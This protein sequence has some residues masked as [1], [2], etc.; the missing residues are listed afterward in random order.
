MRARRLTKQFGQFSRKLFLYP[1]QR[2]RRSSLVRRARLPRDSSGAMSDGEADNGEPADARDL[3]TWLSREVHELV[4]HV[5]R[6]HGAPSPIQFLREFVSANRPVVVTD[7]FNDWPAMERWSLDYL[8]DAMGDT[9]ISVNVTPDG[10]G[11]ALLS[12]RGWTVSGTGDDEKTPDEVFVV[13]EERKMTM[14]EFVD[15]LE[16]PVGDDHGDVH[17]SHRPPVPYVSRQCGSLLEEFPKLVGDCSHE[18]RFASDAMGKAPDAVNLWIGDERSE[19]TFHRD[20]YENVY[21]VVRG[22]KVFHLLPPCDGRLLGYREAPAAKFTSSRE[23]GTFG[24]ELE[25][26]RRLVSWASATPASL[27]SRA[28]TVPEDPV[29]PIVV[30]VRAGECLYLPAMWYHHVTQA[31][32]ERGTPAIA[33]N[34]WYDMNF[35]DRYAYARFTQEAHARFGGENTPR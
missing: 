13:P 10:R 23:G 14:R 6:V 16:T 26:P 34:Y 12:T 33:V 29:V 24:V 2:S 22:V 8:A 4:S 15:M 5:P 35:D 27:R 20:H 31:R 7:A 1:A 17:P 19:T 18:M 9:K 30:E 28:C 11:D 21:C 3:F 32:D 25:T